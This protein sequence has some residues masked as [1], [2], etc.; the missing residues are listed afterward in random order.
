MFKLNFETGL[1]PHPFEGGSV[2]VNKARLADPSGGDGTDSKP[3]DRTTATST[4]CA[5]SA[6][7]GGGSS[8]GSTGGGASPS[9]PVATA[10]TPL[11]GGGRGP[12]SPGGG[13][14]GGG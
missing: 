11:G 7:G 4:P 1:I 3:S 9:L 2:P 13:G 10:R 12:P 14:G 8:E 5:D 6:G